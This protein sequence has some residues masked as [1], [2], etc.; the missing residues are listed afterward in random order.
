MGAGGAVWGQV[1]PHLG[2]DGL[3]PLDQGPAEPAEGQGYGELLL[4]EVLGRYS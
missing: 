1:M 3:Y 2:N 4:C